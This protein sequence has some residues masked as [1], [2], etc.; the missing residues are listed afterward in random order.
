MRQW[1]PSLGIGWDGRSSA[2]A[3]VGQNCAAGIAGGAASITGNFSAEEARHPKV[4]LRGRLASP[5]G[6]DHRGP[7]RR[8]HPRAA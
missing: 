2:E 3:S 6:P 4:Q 1:P 8:A 7:H 5:A